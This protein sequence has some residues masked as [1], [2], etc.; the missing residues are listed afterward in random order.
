MT[1][2][3]LEKEQLLSEYSP[4]R[5]RSSV[6]ARHAGRAALFLH[7]G[8]CRRHFGCRFDPCRHFLRVWAL[9]EGAGSVELRLRAHVTPNDQ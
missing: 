4:L 9:C 1:W 7:F 2:L 5:A 8:F 3:E 6:A